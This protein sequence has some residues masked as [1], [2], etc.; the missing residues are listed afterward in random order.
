MKNNKY[1][2]AHNE[3]IRDAIKKIDVNKLNTLIVLD[4]KKKL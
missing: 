1:T 2:I 4:E 3:S